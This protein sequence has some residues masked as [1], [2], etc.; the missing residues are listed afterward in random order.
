MHVVFHRFL[1]VRVALV[2][3]CAGLLYHLPVGAQ[4]VGATDP[5]PRVA[6]PRVT[7]G[8]VSTYGPVTVD[9]ANAAK[10]SYGAA[11]NGAVYASSQTYHPTPGGASVP[12][13]V[14]QTLPKASVA[15]AVGRFARSVAASW[16]GPIGTAFA[17]W[18]LAQELGFTVTPQSDGAGVDFGLNGYLWNGNS[19]GSVGQPCHG[20]VGPLEAG[21]CALTVQHSQPLSQ[22]DSCTVNVTSATTATTTCR[23]IPSGSMLTAGST[24]GSAVTNPSSVDAFETAVA[25]KSDYVPAST[26][27]PG[28]VRDA[29]RAGEAIAPSGVE[30]TGPSSSPGP[31]SSKVDAVSGNTTVTNVTNNYSYAG[32]HVTV[33]QTTNIVTTAP[34]GGVVAS[35]SETAQPEE[36]EQNL[37]VPG[38]TVPKRDVSVSF[39]SV[40]VGF[41]AGACPADIPVNLSSGS[42]VIEF[43]AVCAHATGIIRPLVV[44]IAAIMALFIA[45]PRGDS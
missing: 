31:Q 23:F 5:V 1:V 20:M 12:I 28:A 18:N 10:F 43:D 25:A 19:G 3:A 9:A 2:C 29:L 21:R 30:V 6:F 33:T 26:A 38:D 41:G 14:K 44:A 4:P 32:D 17:V 27:L 16:T 15:A 34:G 13:T 42:Y 45:V 8:N 11:S 24:R 7:S 39:A 36:K 40:D 22:W 37:D 35:T